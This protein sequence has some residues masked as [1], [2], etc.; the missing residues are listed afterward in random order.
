MKNFAQ[1]ILKRIETE[2]IDISQEV[3]DEYSSKENDIDIKMNKEEG[4]QGSDILAKI[5]SMR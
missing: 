5:N 2:D 1:N 4:K 3:E